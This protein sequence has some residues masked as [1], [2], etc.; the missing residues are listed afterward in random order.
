MNETLGKFHSRTL[1]NIIEHNIIT[2]QV[3]NSMGTDW[4][5]PPAPSL[6]KLFK[7]ENHDQ[8]F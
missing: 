7:N 4:G 3:G 5:N 6:K 1:Y 8:T 2:K